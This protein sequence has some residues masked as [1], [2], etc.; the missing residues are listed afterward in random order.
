MIPTYLNKRL[1][2]AKI[3]AA[4]KQKP[5]LLV[6]DAKADKS[7]G[8]TLLDVR[9]WVRGRHRKPQVVGLQGVQIV[10]IV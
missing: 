7:P 8:N 10:V 6:S 2:S 4:S 3:S 9:I 5:F 1:C